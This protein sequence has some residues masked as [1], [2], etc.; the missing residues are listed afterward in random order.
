[1]IPSLTNRKKGKHIAKQE[2]HRR[3]GFRNSH[4]DAFSAFFGLH[5]VVVPSFLRDSGAMFLLGFPTAVS[6]QSSLN[7]DSF[8]SPAKSMH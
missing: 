5:I 8:T 2:F 7:G 1:M 4:V 3:K 6:Q